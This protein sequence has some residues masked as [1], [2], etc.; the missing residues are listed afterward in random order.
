M[1]TESTSADDATRRDGSRLSEGL[2]AA[3]AAPLRLPCANQVDGC[4]CHKLQRPPVASCKDG[5]LH[6]PLS[7][8]ALAWAQATAAQMAA[9]LRDLAAAARERGKQQP[10]YQAAAARLEG[11]FYAAAD[12]IDD[13]CRG[14]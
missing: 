12:V 3:G 11:A 5:C 1:T 14:A 4:V 6:P 10:E 8:P 9:S 2:G 13:R 7:G